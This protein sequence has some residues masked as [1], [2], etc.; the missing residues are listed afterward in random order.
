MQSACNPKGQATGLTNH[1]RDSQEWEN[2][3]IIIIRCNKRYVD[4]LSLSKYYRC[5][6]LL[7]HM[8]SAK[9]RQMGY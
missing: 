9:W 5:S 4:V 6:F 2:R 3:T 7:P 8:T 1:N